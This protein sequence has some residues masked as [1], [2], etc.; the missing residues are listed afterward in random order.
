MGLRRLLFL[1]LF[2]STTLWA[3]NYVLPLGF[4]PINGRYLLPLLVNGTK[5]LA[6]IDSGSTDL[7]LNL[8]VK[9][10]NNSALK[11]KI[12]IKYSDSSGEIAPMLLNVQLGEKLLLKNQ[13]VGLYLKKKHAMNIIGLGYN[14]K[15]S[16]YLDGKYPTLMKRLNDKYNLN[17]Q[18]SLLLCPKQKYGKLLLGPLPKEYKKPV[19]AKL[20]ANNELYYT[21]WVSAIKQANDKRLSTKDNYPA[22]IDNGTTGNVI[23]PKPLFE[24]VKNYLYSSTRK[25]N[26]NIDPKFWN[27]KICY[28]ETLIDKHGWPTINFEFVDVNGR[29]VSLPLPSAH[30]LT[31]DGCNSGYIQLAFTKADP[32]TYL[33][34]SIILG[35]PFIEQFIT[36]F[37]N[38]SNP[39]VVF[40]EK[41]DICNLH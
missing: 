28:K 41:G 1:F 18:F 29:H 25:K 6:M 5:T 24:S 3:N 4:N 21:V 7:N 38:T 14:S 33:K 10:K 34:N 12:F 32:N 20:T 37:H 36:S 35:A 22:I 39:K 23:L 11:N 2:Y 9:Y 15:S 27:G 30:Y 17:T 19:I 16:S 26:K 31:H 40:R 8:N 13:A